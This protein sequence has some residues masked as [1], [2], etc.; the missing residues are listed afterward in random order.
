[1]VSLYGMY[2]LIV[3]A[4]LLCKIRTDLGMGAIIPAR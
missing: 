2:D 3:L 1:M 4:V